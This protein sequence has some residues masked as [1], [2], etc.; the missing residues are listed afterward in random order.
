MVHSWFLVAAVLACAC[1]SSPTPQSIV[2]S[3][4]NRQ[5]GELQISRLTGLKRV[6]TMVAFGPHGRS[7][8]TYETCVIYPSVAMVSISAGSIFVLEGLCK[9]K[10]ISCPEPSFCT[11]A[12]PEKAEELAKTA[13]E[14]NRELLFERSRWSWAATAEDNTDFWTIRASDTREGVVVYRFSKTTGLL[15]S[16]SRGERSREYLDWRP[17]GGIR[18]PFELV[19]EVEGRPVFHIKLARVSMLNDISDCG[20]TFA[21]IVAACQA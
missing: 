3:A 4:L 16:K 21:P 5:G 15:A 11:P 18:L 6:G 20:P 9:G 1:A 14:A 8:G 10:S 7:E 2:S 17:L 19:D 13:T 12:S